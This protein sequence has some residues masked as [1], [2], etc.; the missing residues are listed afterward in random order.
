LLDTHAH[1]AYF[2]DQFGLSPKR[3]GRVF[4]GVETEHFS[5]ATASPKSADAP[6]TVLFYGQFNPLHGIETIIQA[7]RQV[8]DEG[9]LRVRW[10][11]VGTGQ[12]EGRI[13]GLLDEVAIDGLQ[14]HRWVEYDKL[15]ELM[16]QADVCLGIFS[17]S[18]KA[19]RVIPNK[20]FQVLSVGKPLITRDSPAIR[21]LVSADEPGIYLVPPEDPA[22]LVAALSEFSSQAQGFSGRL[23]YTSLVPKI[24]VR[25]VGKDCR[26]EIEHVI[27][28]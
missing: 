19:S 7:A 16:M 6:I 15:L 20:V 14:W 27:S 28:E 23:L 1:A 4:V 11:I 10:V 3:V 5:R 17:Y 25:S 21:E 9:M 24:E 18:G 22:A 12:E 13:K 2:V 26:C 8:Q